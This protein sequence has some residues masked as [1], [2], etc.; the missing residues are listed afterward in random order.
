M[1]KLSELLQK[2]IYLAVKYMNKLNK[3][4]IYNNFLK[5]ILISMQAFR[6]ERE[7][8]KRK[9]YIVT[10]TFTNAMQNTVKEYK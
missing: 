2:I 5:Q 8:L 10:E 4:F 1:Q 6:A 7:K 9:E 3:L